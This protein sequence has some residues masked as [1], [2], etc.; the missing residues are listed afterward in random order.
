MIKH[1]EELV[2]TTEPVIPPTPRMGDH[3]LIATSKSITEADHLRRRMDR[4]LNCLTKVKRVLGDKDKDK[5]VDM[6]VLARH[7]EPINNIGVDLQ[8]SCKI[9]Y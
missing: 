2:A 4:V 9:C 5:E 3:Q 6:R 1:L 8:K 7:E